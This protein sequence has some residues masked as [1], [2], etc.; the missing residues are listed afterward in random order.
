VRIRR[1]ATVL[2]AG[3]LATILGM[4]LT[5]AARADVTPDPNWNEIFAPGLN[6]QSNTLCF[7]VPNGTSSIGTTIQEAYSKFSLKKY[8]PT[9]AR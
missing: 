7:D 5:G 4:V 9:A 1:L 6:T 2:F 3:T 8:S